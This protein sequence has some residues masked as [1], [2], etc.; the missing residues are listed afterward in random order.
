VEQLVEAERAGWAAASIKLTI[1]P[2]PYINLE[3]RYR[4]FARRGLHAF[5]ADRRLNLDE[6]LRLVELGRARTRELVLLANVAYT[7]PDGLDG[8]VRMARRFR[9]AGAHGI[10]LNLCCPNMSFNLDVAGV[11]QAGRPSSGASVGQD[12]EAVGPIV[13]AVREAVALPIVAKLT[14]EGG[15]IGLVARRAFEAGADAVAG[16]ANRLG[17]PDF[18]VHKPLTSVYRLQ[19][20]HSISCLS[21]PWIKPLGLRDVY[22]MRLACGPD[23][24][25]VGY[26]G[27]RSYVDAVQ[28]AMVGADLVGVCTE[29]MV[30]GFDFL[31]KLMEQLRRYMDKM[32][33][34]CWRQMR[35]LLVE[36]LATADRLVL[37]AGHAAIDEVRCNACGLCV[38]IGH[39]HAIQGR[40]GEKPTIRVADCDACGTCV[41][42]CPSGAIRIVE[43]G[44]AADPKGE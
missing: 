15:R 36:Q 21:G 24:L 13:A 10:E 37:S 11:Q 23:R 38:R 8:W 12:A 2:P 31:P 40:S 16:T 9:D 41:D 25:L 39:C 27:V 7:G 26:G 42:V 18:D 44:R 32:G 29:T 43:R 4:W 6:G 3:P 14:A 17:I 33:F 22:E 28:Y 20:S 5:T 35:G 19:S 30:R 1:D 34:A